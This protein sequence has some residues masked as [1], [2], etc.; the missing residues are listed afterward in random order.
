MSVCSRMLLVP[1]SKSM[2]MIIE[3][4]I[5]NI[6]GRN[7]YFYTVRVYK[8]CILFSRGFENISKSREIVPFLEEILS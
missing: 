3:Y 7:E 6:H 1:G 4:S 5:F 2:I 8:L